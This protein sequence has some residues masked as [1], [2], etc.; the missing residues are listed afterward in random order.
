MLNKEKAF[1]KPL[2]HAPV[3]TVVTVVY[4]LVKAGRKKAFSQCVA[5]VQQ[6]DYPAVEHLIIDGLSDDGTLEMIAECVKNSRVKV[7]QIKDSGIYD[8]MNNGIQH[9]SG[10][11]VTF[12]N[13]DDYFI[14]NDAVTISIDALERTGA[15]FSCATV[16]IEHPEKRTTYFKPRFG[17]VLTHMPFPHPA[18]FVRK[19]CLEQLGGFKVDFR[20]AADHDLV[21]RLMLF[22]FRGI[23]INGTL[24]H[25]RVGG[26]SLLT[27]QQ[28]QIEL[29]AILYAN[30]KDIVNCTPDECRQVARRRYVPFS[31]LMRIVIKHGR[32]YRRSLLWHNFKSALGYLRKRMLLN[33]PDCK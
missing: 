2:T 8:G 21:F 25:F 13:S 4:N 28:K 14:A 20:V 30:L 12:L 5:S 16:R 26:A 9:A 18:M 19:T 24:A 23:V 17:R 1:D 3:V 29:A 22:N 15:A 33:N 6:Q 27:Q 11:Y 32:Q 7:I 10:K 31:W